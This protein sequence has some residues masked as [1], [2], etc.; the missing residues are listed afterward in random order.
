MTAK[1]STKT[2]GPRKPYPSFPLWAHQNGQWCKKIKGRFR[3]YGTWEDPKAA[4]ENYNR[5]RVYHETGTPVGLPDAESGLTVKQ[6]IDRFCS[7]LEDR[8]NTGEASRRHLVQ[9]INTAKIIVSVL[10]RSRLVVSLSGDDFYKLRT[11][12][13]TRVKVT[14][15]QPPRPISPATLA[16][17]IRRTVSIFNFAIKEGLVDRVVYGSDFA[18]ITRKQRVQLEQNNST[19]LLEPEVIRQ[20]LAAANYRFRAMLLL[21]INCGMGNADIASLEEQ[22]LDLKNGWIES[23]RQKTSVRRCAKLWPETVE[24]LRLVIRNKHKPIDPADER[25]VFITRVGRPY[26]NQN[27]ITQEFL[28]CKQAAGIETHRGCGFY[29]LRHTLR[30]E[31]AR[32]S[33]ETAI[34]WIMGHTRSRIDDHYIHA[35]PKE[36]IAELSAKVRSWL[37]SGEVTP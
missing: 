20:L 27:A 11:R 35:P 30:T 33:D 9:C 12:F 37:F 26:S 18:T 5:L 28:H 21:G 24:A 7:R 22:F 4:L 13:L 16:G 36:R 14:G 6:A 8:V 23:N 32:Y 10:D 2:A 19:K 3:F 17:H 1:K 15:K 25:L 31:A 34:R 29:S